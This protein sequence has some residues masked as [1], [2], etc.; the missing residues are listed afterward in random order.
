MEP[1]D[2]LDQNTGNVL[3]PVFFKLHELDLLLVGGGYVALEKL[4]ALLRNSPLARIT[5]VAEE[6]RQP[7]L[8]ELAEAHPHVRLKER[9]FKKKD[10]KG[11]DL[12]ML[13][14]DNPALHAH[15]KKLAR[16]RRLLVN[17]ADTPALCDFYLGSIVKKGD[18]KL[19]ISTNGKSPTLAKRLRENLEEALPDEIDALLGRLQEIRNQLKGDFEAK[20]KALDA[21][22]AGFR[23]PGLQQ[24]GGAEG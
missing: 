19:G 15:I 3:F 2:Y 21:L 14:T 8:R 9:A 17:V 6:V 5:V 24:E 4:Q 23:P 22:T 20:T 11:K 1:T 12:A 7:R 13:A 16:K 10:L 18:L